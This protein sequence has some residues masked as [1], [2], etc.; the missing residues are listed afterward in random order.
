MLPP[1]SC[2]GREHL[3]LMAGDTQTKT[4]RFR[5]TGLTIRWRRGGGRVDDVS[6]ALSLAEQGDER[7]I[8]LPNRLFGRELWR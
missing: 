1:L 7:V 3:H 4:G 2:K 8:G 5:F 6:L